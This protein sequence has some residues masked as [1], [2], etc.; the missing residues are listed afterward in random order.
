M[1]RRGGRSRW[2]LGFRLSLSTTVAILLTIGIGQTLTVSEKYTALEQRMHGGQKQPLQLSIMYDIPRE[3]FQSLAAE[4]EFGSPMKLLQFRRFRE[5]YRIA[6]SET[7][8]M[9]F[10]RAMRFS[11]LSRVGDWRPV[12]HRGS[13]LSLHLHSITITLGITSRG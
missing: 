6:R 10:Y 9:R 1:S 5:G 4:Q 12:T 11:W 8:G 7:E 3:A 2:D 13:A